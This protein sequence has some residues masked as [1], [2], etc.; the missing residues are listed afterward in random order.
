MT[1]IG[2]RITAAREAKRL[3]RTALADLVGV[4]PSTVKRWERGDSYP[5]VLEVHLIARATQ[6][7]SSDLF[8]TADE[9]KREIT[10]R[11]ES[12]RK[13]TLERQTA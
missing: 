8:G 1:V 12:N 11:L 7:R 2:S 5:D 4:S 3:P 9:L 10:A 6:V 13:A